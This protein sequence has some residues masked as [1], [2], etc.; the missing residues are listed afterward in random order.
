MAW[1]KVFAGKVSGMAK[2][3][4]VGNLAWSA[5]HDDLLQL[6][7]QHGTVK[8]AQVISDRATGRSRGFGFVEMENDADADKAIEAL[9]GLEHGSRLLK[10]NAAK[11]RE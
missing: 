10:V 8:N 2:N 6:F 9:N 3:I 5:T 4:F 7:G 1:N 11:P